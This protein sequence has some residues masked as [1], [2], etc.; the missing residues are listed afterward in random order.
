M[1]FK[2][3]EEISDFIYLLVEKYILQA[4]HHMYVFINKP[5]PCSLRRLRIDAAAYVSTSCY[6]ILFVV[7]A[8]LVD[9]TKYLFSKMAPIFPCEHSNLNRCRF[10]RCLM[11]MKNPTM[12]ET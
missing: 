4:S 8:G 6:L 3:N 7:K 10:A 2:K 9:I 1:K 5:T 11:Q 12:A